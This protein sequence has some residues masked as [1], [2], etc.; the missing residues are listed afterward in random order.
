[1]RDLAAAL[2]TRLIDELSNQ[3]VPAALGTHFDE[4]EVH[5]HCG[6]LESGKLLGRG[7]ASSALRQTLP[8]GERDD[9]QRMV[10]TD[11]AILVQWI[12]ERTCYPQKFRGGVADVFFGQAAPS[13]V[14]ERL[15]A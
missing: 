5:L 3:V 2:T 13:E 12:T 11:W 6:V 10:G 7:D 1:M 8:E 9:D 4:V 15:V 14:V